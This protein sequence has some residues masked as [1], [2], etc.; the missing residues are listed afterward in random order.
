MRI[1]PR[2]SPNSTASNELMMN[3]QPVLLLAA[4][5]DCQ[6]RQAASAIIIELNHDY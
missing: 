2:F 1:C 3:S 6:V 4:W 5:A